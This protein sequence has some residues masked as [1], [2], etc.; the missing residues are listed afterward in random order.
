MPVL[1]SLVPSFAKIVSEK[2]ITSCVQQYISYS[3]N[4]PALHQKLKPGVFI[5]SSILLLQLLEPNQ[6]NLLFTQS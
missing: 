6:I 2:P 5:C 1:N 4:N 3:S